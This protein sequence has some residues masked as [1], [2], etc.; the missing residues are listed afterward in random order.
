M[1]AR[2]RRDEAMEYW[3]HNVHYQPVILDAVPAGCEAALDVGCGDGLLA[4]RLA[5]RCAAVT[6]IDRDPQMITLARQR[7]DA[8]AAGLSPASPPNGTPADPHDPDNRA[9]T[10]PPAPGDPAPT[11][12]PAVT[13]LQGDFLTHPFEEDSFGF[14]CANTS[15]HHMGTEAA[16][17]A[18]ARVVRPG[19]RLAVLGLG[20]NGSPA[21]LLPDLVA[22]PL[23]RYYQRTRGEGYPGDPKLPPDLTWAEVRETARRVLPGVRYRRH[24]LWRYSLVWDKPVA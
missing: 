16:L 13:F 4:V 17:R 11:P 7:A 9:R 10:D 3:N 8:L 22:A 24:L 18:M 21:D 1:D 19:G 20:E 2:E 5:S 12:K 23:N 6:G 15:I 14:V